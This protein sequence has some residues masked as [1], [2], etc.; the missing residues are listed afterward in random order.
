[1]N[2]LVAGIQAILN[3]KKGPR[4]KRGFFFWALAPWL[5]VFIVVM[6]FMID[7]SD[8]RRFALLVALELLAILVLLGLWDAQRFWWAW[9]GVGALVLL[10]YVAYLISML[11]EEW[12][13]IK[14]PKHRGESTLVNA[15]IGFVLL[16]LP[17]L[18][19]ALFGRLTLR[20]EQPRQE[21]G[22]ADEVDS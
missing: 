22:S 20:E 14:V 1:M 7:T 4:Q 2:G 10:S 8:P 17:G 13:A 18:W 5:V 6:G 15:L 3:Q 9:R 11:I 16:G 21:S 19:Y 12:G